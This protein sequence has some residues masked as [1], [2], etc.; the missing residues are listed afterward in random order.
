MKC[1]SDTEIMVPT[2]DS[3]TKLY[4]FDK[5]YAPE[6]TQAVGAHLR[7]LQLEVGR[8]VVRLFVC[9]FV[10]L[11]NRFGCVAWAWHKS[12]SRWGRGRPARGAAATSPLSG[13]RASR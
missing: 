7:L 11:F 12:D 13:C 5:V 3:R 6:A 2:K 8:F 4:E 9:L 1:I 10:C